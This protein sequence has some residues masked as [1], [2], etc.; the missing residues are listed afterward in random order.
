LPKCCGK[1]IKGPVLIKNPLALRKI[2]PEKMA[3]IPKKPMQ[4]KCC[5]SVGAV[6]DNDAGQNQ[7]M[8]NSV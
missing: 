4:S 7:D 3:T 6:A 1:K 2:K 5:C 8:V